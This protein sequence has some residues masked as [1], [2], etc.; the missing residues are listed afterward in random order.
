MMRIRKPF[1]GA[2]VGLIF[3]S[4]AAGFSPPDYKIP[5][6]KQSDKALHFT[7]FFL[8]TLCFY[9]ILETN[10]RK[11]V[12]LTFTVC[13]LGL[14][15]ASEVIQGLLP[16]H[17]DFDYYDIVANVLGSLLALGLCNWYHKR[18]LERKRAARGYTAVA[19]DE[20]R[21][22]ELGENVEGQ[23]SGVVRPT[24]DEELDRWDENAED[25]ETTE[26]EATNGRKSLDDDGK[27]R[28]D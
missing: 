9:W 6:Y 1:A 21:D 20:E 16:I 15:F 17:R 8:L 13:T 14:G 7:A 27:K 22:I 28:S 3:I 2:F 26:P 5:T 23:E 10:R 12:Q 18:M 4:A 11:V 25:W 19:G 24:V